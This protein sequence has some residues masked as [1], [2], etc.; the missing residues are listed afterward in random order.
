MTMINRRE[1]W[2]ATLETHYMELGE[3]TTSEGG[4]GEEELEN[5][6]II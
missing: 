1:N 2:T 3:P 5:N 4:D 6:E